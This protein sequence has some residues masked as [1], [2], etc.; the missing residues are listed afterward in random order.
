MLNPKATK[1]LASKMKLR[2][3]TTYTPLP[4]KKTLKTLET[5]TLSFK[6]LEISLHVHFLKKKA[7][8]P[9]QRYT[10]EPLRDR[11]ELRLSRP[12]LPGSGGDHLGTVGALIIRIRVWGPL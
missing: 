11:S 6:S 10:P 12:D 1:S 2:T 4:T 8:K 5:E 7:P 3:Y 9:S